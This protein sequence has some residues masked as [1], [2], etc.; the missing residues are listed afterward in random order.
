MRPGFYKKLK[1]QLENL[2]LLSVCSL[3]GAGRWGGYPSPIAPCKLQTF[4]TAPAKQLP[5]QIFR[6]TLKLELGEALF[7]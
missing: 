7:A 1:D 3:K 5:V 2:I 6:A 4:Q